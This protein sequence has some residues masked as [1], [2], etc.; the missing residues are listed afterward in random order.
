M[1]LVR[2]CSLMFW[3]SRLGW[4]RYQVTN[5]SSCSYGLPWLIPLLT[6]FPRPFPAFLLA[7]SHIQWVRENGLAEQTVSIMVPHP[8]G[9]HV[10]ESYYMYHG[11]M[12]PD[13]HIPMYTH[14][15]TQSCVFCLY[16]EHHSAKWID[17]IAFTSSYKILVM[18][19]LSKLKTYTYQ[20]HDSG[21]FYHLDVCWK[22]PMYILVNCFY[23]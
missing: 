4:L 17:Y 22:I 2:S 15:Y 13:Y 11:R 14:L 16:T 6:T 19:N 8:Y 5:C 10:G 23:K 7:L 9:C 3:Y 20:T 18:S 21:S 12:D 1:V